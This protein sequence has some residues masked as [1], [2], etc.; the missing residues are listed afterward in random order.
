[1]VIKVP[2]LS[3][4]KLKWHIS[5]AR[6]R[7]KPASLNRFSCNPVRIS[8][9]ATMRNATKPMQCV[10]CFSI[11]FGAISSHR[12]RSRVTFSAFLFS[13]WFGKSQKKKMNR[14]TRAVLGSAQMF[15]AD[16]KRQAKTLWLHQT[17]GNTIY[18]RKNMKKKSC[19]TFFIF[20]PR[21]YTKHFIEIYKNNLG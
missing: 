3:H 6:A 14:N 8:C 16:I 4:I 7:A 9:I 1:M 17:S 10:C 15:A 18:D 21:I 12:R 19:R 11:W 20:V 5:L 2:K 13:K